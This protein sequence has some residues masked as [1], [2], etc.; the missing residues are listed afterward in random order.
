MDLLT[1]KE[2]ILQELITLSAERKELLA[3]LEPIERR[4]TALCEE[5][6]KIEIK[7]TKVQEIPP[8]RSGLRL[9]EGEQKK[10]RSIQLLDMLNEGQKRELLALLSSMIPQE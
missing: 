10:E 4:I 1:R 6:R 8:G 3:K 2:E 9:K 5:K 7:L